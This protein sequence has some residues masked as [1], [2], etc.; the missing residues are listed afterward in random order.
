M[1]GDSTQP[2]SPDRTQLLAAA[3]DQLACPE[4][5]AGLRMEAAALLCCE[6]GRR[7]PIVDSI[8][9]LIAKPAGQE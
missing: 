5:F 9:V 4:C 2:E 1:P 3:L 7:Y 8:P 6:C